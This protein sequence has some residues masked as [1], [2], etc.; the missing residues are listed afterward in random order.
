LL[1]RQNRVT[2]LRYQSVFA[3]GK[4]EDSKALATSAKVGS[5]RTT[6]IGSATY[7]AAP[8]RDDEELVTN[9]LGNLT[10]FVISCLPSSRDKY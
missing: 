8:M 4:F 3:D 7:V 1:L 2:L 9:K 5:K 6:G 10:L